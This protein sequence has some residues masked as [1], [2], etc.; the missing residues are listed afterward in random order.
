VCS[1][2]NTLCAARPGRSVAG[3]ILCDRFVG[4]GKN[5]EREDAAGNQR[6]EAEEFETRREHELF[7]E[8]SRLNNELV[9][10]QRELAKANEQLRAD[11]AELNRRVQE[12]MALRQ[13]SFVLQ[14]ALE[15]EE[16]QERILSIAHETMPAAE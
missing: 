3:R 1:C 16:L 8:L 9:T 11:A 10:A 12:L 15:L 14:S 6:P 2:D 5:V 4:R 7:N 13:A